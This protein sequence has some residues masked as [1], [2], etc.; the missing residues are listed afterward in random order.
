MLSD[1]VLGA[2]GEPATQMVVWVGCWIL[3]FELMD[4]VTIVVSLL[5]GFPNG[6]RWGCVGDYGMFW[7]LW[8]NS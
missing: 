3:S 6:R 5:L 2:K 8:D 7:R 4:G 1:V